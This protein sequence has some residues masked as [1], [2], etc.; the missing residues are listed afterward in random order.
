LDI[1]KEQFQRSVSVYNGSD[2]NAETIRKIDSDLNFTAFNNKPKVFIIN[3]SQ[4]I[5]EMRRLLEVIE[6]EKSNAYFIF[7]STDRTKFSTANGKNNKDQETQALRSRGA[8]FD[9]KPISTSTISEYLFSVLEKI[10]PEQKIPDIFLEEGLPL[11]AENSHNNL[12]LA[13]NDFYQAIMGE[14][15]DSKSLQE[16]LGYEDEEENTTILYNLSIKNKSIMAKVQGLDISSF[17]TYSWKILNSIS[18]QSLLGIPAKELWKEKLSK[19]IISSG[20]LDDLLEVYN[21]TNSLCTGYFN[22]NVFISLLYQY[23]KTGNLPLLKK[24]KKI[25]IAKENLC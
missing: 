23:M 15:Y 16:L 20:N 9:I 6:Q 19:G 22:E 10:D 2:V 21:V 1:S 11:V 18:I 17:F 12:R 5:K 13:L 8:Y 7:T 4:L 24:V 14:L 3:E 25:K